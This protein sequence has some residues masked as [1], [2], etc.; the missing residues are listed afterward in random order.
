LALDFDEYKDVAIQ[1]LTG[2]REICNPPVMNTDIDICVRVLGEPGITE[3]Q[4][5]LGFKHYLRE[6]GWT[7][8]GDYPD[9]DTESWK[10]DEYNIILHKTELSY[11]LW[12][13]ATQVAKKLNLLNKEDRIMLF[14][15]VIG[16]QFEN[17]QAQPEQFEVVEEMPF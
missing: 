17:F 11:N 13:V 8:H 9:S 5:I 3:E 12:Y 14:D 1:F 4:Q 15:A 6:R 10:K 7:Q 2:S 16:G